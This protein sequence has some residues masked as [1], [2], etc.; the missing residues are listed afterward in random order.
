MPNCSYTTLSEE[1]NFIAQIMNF[2]LR[3]IPRARAPLLG[4]DPDN[5]LS[6]GLVLNLISF[7]GNFIFSLNIF[8]YRDKLFPPFWILTYSQLMRRPCPTCNGPNDWEVDPNYIF[9]GSS[10]QFGDVFPLRALLENS[11]Y[12]IDLKCTIWKF[13]PSL[14]F[15]FSFC[16][17]ILTLDGIYRLS[18][19][20]AHKNLLIK[21]FFFSVFVFQVASRIFFSD[22]EGYKHISVYLV[23]FAR[24]Q[25][26]FLR[27]ITLHVITESLFWWWCSTATSMGVLYTNIV[28]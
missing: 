2:T 19:D 23:L 26:F 22:I 10:R 17:P 27:I 3:S 15:L 5:A 21:V 4:I 11:Y 24:I 1:T 18:M 14:F 9:W 16:F 8:V 12:N 7:V 13:S 25:L 28:R 20:I 6:I